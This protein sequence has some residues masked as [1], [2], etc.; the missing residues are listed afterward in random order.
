MWIEEAK[1]LFDK[2]DDAN[3]FEDGFARVMIDDKEFAIDKKGKP[4]E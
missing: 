4:F 1:L 2:Y 3:A